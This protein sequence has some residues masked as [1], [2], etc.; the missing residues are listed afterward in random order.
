MRILKNFGALETMQIITVNYSSDLS[1][2]QLI[3]RCALICSQS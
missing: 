2:G 1:V 3:S